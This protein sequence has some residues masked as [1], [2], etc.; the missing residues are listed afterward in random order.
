MAQKI[1][2]GGFEIGDGLELNGKVLSASGGGGAALPEVTAED[3]GD[4]LAVVDGVWAKSAP[5]AGGMVVNVTA[6][7]NEETG[8]ASA[9]ADKTVA[10]IIEAAKIG[11][12]TANIVIDEAVVAILP[13]CI[14]DNGVL[15]FGIKAWDADNENFIYFLV[16]N[17]GGSGDVWRINF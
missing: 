12:V 5:S 17:I 14:V 13:L 2:C 16:G 10:E 7:Y 15:S 1:A 8:E 3:N 9:T 11:A 4:V 6:T